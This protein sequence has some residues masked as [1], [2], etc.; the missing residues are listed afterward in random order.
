MIPTE[1]ST[2][3][4]SSMAVTYSTYPIPAP[5]SSAGKMIPI[6]PSL[7]NSLTVASGYSPASS[8]FMTCGAISRAAKSRTLRRKCCCS[9]LSW[10]SKGC[11]LRRGQWGKQMIRTQFARREKAELLPS[12]DVLQFACGPGGQQIQ[13]LFIAGHA[14]RLLIGE[15]EIAIG[16]NIE[17]AQAAHAQTRLDAQF[18]AYRLFQLR[19]PG[20]LFGSNQAALDFH[21]HGFCSSLSGSWRGLPKIRRTIHSGATSTCA[22]LLKNAGLLPSTKCPIHASAKAAITSKAATAG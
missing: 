5:P 18:L 10:K 6:R 16:K 20:A 9:S 15:D 1:P 7:P 17:H 12:S 11:L 2:R 22:G 4:S 14:S 8:H 21:F 19:R 13:N 3:E